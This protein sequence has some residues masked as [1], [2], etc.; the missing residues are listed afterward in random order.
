MRFHGLSDQGVERL[1]RRTLR[2]V[3]FWRFVAEAVAIPRRLLQAV[4]EILDRLEYAVFYFELDA[5]RRYHA[6]TGIDLAAA[7][8]DV[9][10]YADVID[11]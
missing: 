2:A 5:A 4:V 11:P 7:G 9:G 6:L 3:A 10:R 1:S 8:G